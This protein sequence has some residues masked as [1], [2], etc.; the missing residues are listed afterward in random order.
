MKEI[1]FDMD[2]TIADLYGVE[3]WLP[4]LINEQTAPYENA[5]PMVNM[6]SLAHSL[7]RLQRKGYKIGIVSW[8]SKN[9]SKKYE[10]AIEKA[11]KKWLKKHLNSVQFDTI[12]VISY[13]TPKS[14]DRQGILFDDEERNRNAE[15]DGAFEPDQIMEVL[16]GLLRT[17]E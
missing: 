10:K 4:Q 6:N 8:T 14:I 17:G 16:K 5:H 1:W 11:K 3:D 13:G 15:W 12:D 9:A 7:N 2:G